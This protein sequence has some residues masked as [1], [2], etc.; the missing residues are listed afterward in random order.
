M[1]LAVGCYLG[2][3]QLTKLF[4]DVEGIAQFGLQ[5]LMNMASATHLIPP[6]GT[7]LPF[8]SYGGSATLALAFSMGMVL[9]LTRLRPGSGAI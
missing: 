6:K 5:A 9:A 4:T 7:T 8:I 2:L 3:N 1:V